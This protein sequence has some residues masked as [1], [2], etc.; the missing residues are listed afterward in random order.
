MASLRRGS[1]ISAFTLQLKLDEP[2]IISSLA[3]TTSEIFSFSL[4]YHFVFLFCF[5][6]LENLYTI[7]ANTQHGEG[8]PRLI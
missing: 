8:V 1:Y 6:N 3:R 5:L 2:D 4:P 7:T